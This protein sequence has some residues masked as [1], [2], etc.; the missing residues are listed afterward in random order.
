MTDTESD[1]RWDGGAYAL[2]VLIGFAATVA[3]ITFVL[4][5]VGL[6]DYGRRVADEHTLSFLVPLGVDGLTMVG[7]MATYILR[8]AP[9]HVRAYAW[10]VFSVALALSV[11]GN[12]SHGLAHH[13]S[14]QG[15][16]GAAIWPV[17]L[18]FS[19]H[20][21][22]VVRR[23]QERLRTVAI[24]RPAEVD[25]PTPDLPMQDEAKE[26]APRRQLT[27]EG[28]TRQQAAKGKSISQIH[29]ALGARGENV[30]RSTVGRWVKEAKT[31]AGTDDEPDDVD[32]E[33]ADLIKEEVTA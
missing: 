16:V 30:S 9:W 8:A 15:L 7:V 2:W 23:W 33:F 4:S 28:Y 14:M 12:L 24:A 13:L 17:L 32:A 1:S 27:P 10:L 18:A 11:A 3:V 26:P 5:F 20:V 21:V 31:P 22:V 19:S 6:D 29:Q 25:V